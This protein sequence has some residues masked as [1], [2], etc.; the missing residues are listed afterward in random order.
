V[1]K[2][3]SVSS[4]PDQ[5]H[6]ALLGALC[7]DSQAWMR[8][9]LQTGVTLA[10]FSALLRLPALSTLSLPWIKDSV[11]DDFR[12]LA[13]QQGRTVLRIERP[14]PLSRRSLL[15]RHWLSDDQLRLRA[16]DWA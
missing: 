10:G 1:L 12:Q 5:S 14:V 6:C 4:A 2:Q 3:L 11:L 15:E 16:D 8:A 7:P 13:Q 9:E